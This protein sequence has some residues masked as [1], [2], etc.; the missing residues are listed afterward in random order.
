MVRAGVIAASGLLALGAA[1]FGASQRGGDG[2]AAQR[3]AGVDFVISGRPTR[4]L[5]PGVSAPIDLRLRNR[6]RH[7]RLV[8]RLHV[9]V[10]V[11]AAHR[12]AGC[13][14]RRDFRVR[15]LPR[16]AYPLRLGPRRSLRLSRLGVRRVPRVRMVDLARVDQD[17]CKGARLTF[18]YTG[19]STRLRR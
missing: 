9:A 14:R 3:L 6:R 19:R 18:R 2:R 5:R 4:V 1:A 8:T 15:Q 10:R 17:A 7:P 11:D 13:S 12:R 16:S